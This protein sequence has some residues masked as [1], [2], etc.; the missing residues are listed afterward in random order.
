MP[1]KIYAALQ[2]DINTGWV[3]LGGF[4]C[5]QRSIVKLVN[6]KNKKSVYCEALKIDSNFIKK[7]KEGNTSKIEAKENTIVASEWYRNKLGVNNT[8][9]DERIKISV[10]NNLIGRFMSCIQ[11]PQVIVR[12]ATWLGVISIVL[13]VIG[14][15]L[16]LYAN[17]T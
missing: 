9:N 12:L 8:K 2:E 14:I 4:E 17:K 15:C 11:H 1:Y 16:G 10:E 3:W 5:N 7:Y 6:E 13:G